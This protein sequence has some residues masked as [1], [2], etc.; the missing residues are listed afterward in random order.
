MTVMLNAPDAVQK[1]LS[2]AISLIG[3]YDFPDNW[4]NLLTTIIENFAA[5][6]SM[7]IQNFG[8]LL[9]FILYDVILWYVIDA[10]TG[11]LAPING[12]LETAHSLFRKYRY[13]LK[14]Q[15]LWTEIKF[16]LDTLAKPLTEL[17][18]VSL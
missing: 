10:P 14:S 11:D 18:I 1:Q 9:L 17:F 5:F 4:P 12:A 2:D 7:C 16:V 8:S 15:K 3:K 6:A 13:E